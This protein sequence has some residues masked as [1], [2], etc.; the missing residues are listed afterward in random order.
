MSAT[1]S[2][3]RSAE[4]ACCNTVTAP[5]IAGLICAHREFVLQSGALYVICKHDKLGD[6]EVAVREELSEIWED[7]SPHITPNFEAVKAAVLGSIKR[8][9]EQC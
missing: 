5:F 4:E 8:Q 6:A 1:G 2:V 3:L 9:L 7:I